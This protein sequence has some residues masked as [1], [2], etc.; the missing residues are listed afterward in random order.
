[1]WSNV[2]VQL[3]KGG[4][5]KPVTVPH[6]LGRHVRRAESSLHEAEAQPCKPEIQC[7]VRKRT[8]GA[9]RQHV[10]EPQRQQSCQSF[11]YKHRAKAFFE[12]PN[13]VTTINTVEIAVVVN[14]TASNIP[15]MQT[16][17]D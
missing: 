15:A 13:D 8:S 12:S 16:G 17:I 11:K 3:R 14:A 7:V 2:Q 5:C 4:G 9:N 1:M 10:V 6:F